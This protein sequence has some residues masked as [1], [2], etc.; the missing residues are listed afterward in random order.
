MAAFV[1]TEPQVITDGAR[2]LRIMAPAWG[3]IGVQVVIG[4]GFSGAGRTYVS[5]L[6]SIFSLW[7]LRFPL[8]WFFS[9][10]AAVVRRACSFW[11]A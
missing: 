8:A 2:F 9:E 3:L 4:S 1:P 5:M 10:E 6:I 11:L 7:V